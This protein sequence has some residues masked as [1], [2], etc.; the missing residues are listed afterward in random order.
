MRRMVGFALT[1]PM[2]MLAAPLVSAWIGLWLDRKFGTGQKLTWICL[3]LGLAAG[4]RET[5][6][7]VKRINSEFDEKK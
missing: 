6:R 3:V 5:W 2:M 7:L 1:I 4:G